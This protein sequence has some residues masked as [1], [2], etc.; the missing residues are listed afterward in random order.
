MHKFIRSYWEHS[1]LY[2][3]LISQC[4]SSCISSF[5]SL[6]RFPE[7]NPL[8]R[9]DSCCGIATGFTTTS[10]LFLPCDRHLRHS[11]TLHNSKFCN[12]C[13]FITHSEQL[14]TPHVFPFGR[15]IPMPLHESSH[16]QRIRRGN[17]STS[18]LNYTLSVGLYAPSTTP[19]YRREISCW[20][21]CSLIDS[22]SLQMEVSVSLHLS[23][24][25]VF[26]SKRCRFSRKKD[27]SLTKTVNYSVEKM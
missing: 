11:H 18:L 27:D 7:Q 10:L 26:I 12:T 16:C 2:V 6:V 5:H 13:F 19:T 9:P 14:T 23:I 3:L 4:C 22:R 20:P 8:L 1:A 17:R 21:S 15:H 24:K 25:S